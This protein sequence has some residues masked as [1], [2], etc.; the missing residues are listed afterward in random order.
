[1]KKQRSEPTLCRG[2]T[3][4]DD[5]LVPVNVVLDFDDEEALESFWER[6][7]PA[8]PSRFQ[9]LLSEQGA[10]HLEM[11]REKSGVRKQRVTM[12]LDP[13]LKRNLEELAGSLGIGYQTLAQIYLAEA[14]DKALASRRRRQTRAQSPRKATTA[15]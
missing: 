15:R 11:L 3:H 10:R 9:V 5:G 7:K 8:Q 13:Q 6:H 14:V 4:C 12:M 2:C 1:M